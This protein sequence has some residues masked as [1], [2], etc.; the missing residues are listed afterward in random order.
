[1]PWIL[2]VPGGAMGVKELWSR[3]ILFIA[4]DA[5]GK[6]V[7][8]SV[9]KRVSSFTFGSNVI[10]NRVEKWA[11][12]EH[13]ERID[14]TFAVPPCRS[15]IVFYRPRSVFNE[16]VIDVWIL[17]DGVLVAQVQVGTYLPIVVEPGGH[18]VQVVPINFFRQTNPSWAPIETS[19]ATSSD[20]TVFLRVDVGPV[21][22]WQMISTKIKKYSE[23]KARQEM[24][25][26]GLISPPP[27]YAGW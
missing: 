23:P 26:L 3:E 16:T 10:R 1:M 15:G 17:V 6:V 13:L 5:H 2:P 14:L 18:D 19:V 9:P 7:A 25:E 22:F 27:A 4:F 21:G 24:D 12:K 8:H 20:E 11:E